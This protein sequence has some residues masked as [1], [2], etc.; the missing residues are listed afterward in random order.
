MFLL[1][2]LYIGEIGIL[3]EIISTLVR[4]IVRN[5]NVLNKANNTRVQFNMDVIYIYPKQLF[6]VETSHTF[7]VGSIE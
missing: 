7:I 3:R 6:R 1:K 2:N 5:F 4:V